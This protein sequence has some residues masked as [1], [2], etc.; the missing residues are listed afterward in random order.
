MSANSLKTEITNFSNNYSYLNLKFLKEELHKKN[1]SFK[2][3]S[4][5]QYLYS[6]KKDH[7]IYD[8]GLNWYSKIS[9]QF[10]IDTVPIKPL[11]DI[12]KTSFPFLDFNIWSIAQLKNYFHHLFTQNVQFIYS[13]FESLN[14]LYDFLL[15][16]NFNVYNNPDKRLLESHFNIKEDTIILRPSI[17]EE[18]AKE[19]FSTIEKTLIDLFIEGEKLNLFDR[20]EYKRIFYNIICSSR[21]NISS[22]LRYSNRR[23]IRKTFVDK[24]MLSEKY[25]NCG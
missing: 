5:N 24:I 7:L 15:N 14:S 13:D 22:M 12:I 3:I 8:A 10:E 4:V 17:S 21:I 19:N 23:E 18:P 25:I 9:N 1:I 20:S 6:L 2:D 11:S 16:K